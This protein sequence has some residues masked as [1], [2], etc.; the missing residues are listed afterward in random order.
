MRLFSKALT[1]VL[2]PALADGNTIPEQPWMSV[3]L[4]PTNNNVD[5]A[6][7]YSKVHAIVV[8]EIV[9]NF[10]TPNG[11]DDMMLQ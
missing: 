9:K 11:W 7:F 2:E 3:V 5:E 6:R 8:V 1:H 10:F 4:D